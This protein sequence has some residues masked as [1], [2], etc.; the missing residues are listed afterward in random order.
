MRNLS[1]KNMVDLI[2]F[3]GFLTVALTGFGMS[4][5]PK[6]TDGFGYADLI[7]KVKVCPA[8]GREIRAVLQRDGMITESEYKE[9]SSRHP[10]CM[11]GREVPP[12]S[13]V[14]DLFSAEVQKRA[15]MKVL[16][17]L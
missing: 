3:A 13:G 15:L 10:L 5:I 6:E 9:L 12:D 7:R 11:T 17:R 16:A 2:I 14:E 8:I 1:R 4:L